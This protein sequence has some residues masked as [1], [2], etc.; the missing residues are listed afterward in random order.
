MEDWLVP[1]QPGDLPPGACVLAFAPHPDDEVYGCGGALAHYA[2]K[3][4]RVEV[5]I[6]TDGSAQVE[7]AAR[8][9]HARA[10]AAESRAALDCL[11]VRVAHF[12]GLADRGLATADDLE[13]R[14]VAA[15]HASEADVV[16][17]PS[18]W[19]VH[20]D[21]RALGAA[22]LRAAGAASARTPWVLL[23][24]I[25]A[26]QRPNL[27]IDVTP[28]WP[29]KQR[30]MAC[31]VSQQQ[32][33]DYARHIEALNVW[34]TYTLPETV[35]WAEGYT[36]VAPAELRAS[37]GLREDPQQALLGLAR[38]TV[39]E[40]A[41]ADHESLRAQLLAQRAAL[42][43]SIEDF[44]RAM[45]QRDA[46]AL[47]LR[48]ELDSREQ[49]LTR[50]IASLSAE[51]ARRGDE[52]ARLVAD[53]AGLCAETERLGDEIARLGREISSLAAVNARLSADA[54][55]LAAE[56][57]ATRQ[58]LA[59]SRSA[60]AELQARLVAAEAQG[61]QLRGFLADMERSTSW[62]ITAPLR[63][64]ASRLRRR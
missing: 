9:A 7:P 10:R 36:R 50:E 16:L 14:V 43:A 30:A 26:A 35:R 38:D 42:R 4:A 18:L 21:H 12:W 32:R 64:L 39:L 8:E 19:E 28:V 22:V 55:R 51:L 61:A 54:A 59:A 46:A 41:A 57:A 45:A 44:H 13:A 48:A 53:N 37:S 20:P 6:V 52:I 47:A 23:Y 63:W 17:A 40:R 33:Q 1:S 5:V 27:L 58:Q 3:G 49:A 62:R 24:E 34:R 56:L 25:G 11:D 15:L 31:F 2:A 29:A 60:E